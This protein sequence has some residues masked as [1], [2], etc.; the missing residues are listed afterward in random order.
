LSPCTE[1]SFPSNVPAL[2]WASVCRHP[3]PPLTPWQASFVSLSALLM[4]DPVQALFDLSLVP[5]CF[6]L[7]FFFPLFRQGPCPFQEFS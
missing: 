2:S 1:P 5:L 3:V 6:H 7:E 4:P